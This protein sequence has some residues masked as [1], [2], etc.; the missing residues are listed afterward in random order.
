MRVL[1]WHGLKRKRLELGTEVLHSFTGIGL[2]IRDCNPEN[3]WGNSQDGIGLMLH[4]LLHL[5]TARVN[6]GVTSPFI[7]DLITITNEPTVD[8][9]SGVGSSDNSLGEITAPGI[10]SV[11]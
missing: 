9:S 2:M 1:T 10:H 5:I 4:W 8:G 7:V 11:F 6:E 3:R